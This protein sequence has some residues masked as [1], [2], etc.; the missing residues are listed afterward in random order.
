MQM[1]GGGKNPTS[2]NKWDGVSDPASQSITD[3]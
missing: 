1:I 3:E 2:N